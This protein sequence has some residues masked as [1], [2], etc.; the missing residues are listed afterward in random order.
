M[1][2]ILLFDE[3][4]NNNMFNEIKK[5][6][7]FIISIPSLISDTLSFLPSDLKTYIGSTILIVLALFIYNFTKK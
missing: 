2:N 4:L 1:F 3:F 5:F 7:N 6:I